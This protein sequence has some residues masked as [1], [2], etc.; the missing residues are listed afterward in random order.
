MTPGSSPKARALEGAER[1]L[2]D[3]S[4]LT[5]VDL[6][7]LSVPEVTR[8]RSCLEELTSP[9]GG[10]NGAY[11]PFSFPYLA[12]LNLQNTF[13]IHPLFPSPSPPGVPAGH[14]L[15]PGSCRRPSAG[16]LLPLLP[17]QQLEGAL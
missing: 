12:T 11:F 2:G 10:V 17:A 7:P 5:P 3:A 15:C 13:Q 14:P 4:G 6:A 8:C 1:L 9:W 16:S